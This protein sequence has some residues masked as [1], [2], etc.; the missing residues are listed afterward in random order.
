MKTKSLFQ[1]LVVLLVVGLLTTSCYREDGVF[2]TLPLPE[3]DE[4]LVDDTE[5]ALSGVRMTLQVPEIANGRVKFVGAV[6]ENSLNNE[7]SYGFMWFDQS[8]GDPE[9]VEIG[10][11]VTTLSYSLEVDDIPYNTHFTACV[12]AVDPVSQDMIA[13]GEISF[14]VPEPDADK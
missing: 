10:R 8:G 11:T 13:S 4:E 3:E 7:V 1:S 5:S 6:V 9:R 14:I 2:S 12:I